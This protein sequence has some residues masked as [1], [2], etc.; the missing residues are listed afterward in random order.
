M[1]FKEKVVLITGGSAGIGAATAEL[2]AKEGASL[3]IVGRNEDRLKEVAAK[4]ELFGPVLTIQAELTNDEDVKAIVDKTIERYGK[5]DVLVNNA[6]ILA[7]GS[8]LDGKLMEDFDRVMNVNVRSVVLLTNYATPHLVKT[9]GNIVNVSSVFGNSF[10]GVP[11]SMAYCMSKAALDH[12]TRGAALE[13]SSEGV[14]VNTVSP[15]PTRTEVLKTAGSTQ[16]WDECRDFFKLSRV[17]EPE[18]IGDLILF[19]ASD[20]AKSITGVDYAIDNGTL[21]KN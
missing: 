5:I 21:L 13:L 12:F 4:C 10:I 6:G 18:E 19:L 16:T 3:A 8:L 2:F 14:R 20:K 11:G 15:G 7:Y 9:K 17:S 1:S